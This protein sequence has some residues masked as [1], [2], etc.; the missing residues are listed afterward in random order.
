MW[1]NDPSHE[2]IGILL[3]TDAFSAPFPPP[4]VLQDFWTGA[5]TALGG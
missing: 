1:S 3:T 5:Y 2:L 4:P